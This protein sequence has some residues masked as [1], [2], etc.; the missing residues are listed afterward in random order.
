MMISTYA[1]GE[2]LHAECSEHRQS[3]A[4][5]ITQERALKSML[6]KVIEHARSHENEGDMIERD[7]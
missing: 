6:E 2:W 7:R 1:R 4:A 5:Q 3:W